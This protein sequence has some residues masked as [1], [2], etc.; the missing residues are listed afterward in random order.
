MLLTDRDGQIVAW[1]GRIGAVECRARDGVLAL[2]DP[3]TLAA[4]VCD[5]K[6]GTPVG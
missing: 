3:P 6:G 5:Q 1:I 4:E 2:N